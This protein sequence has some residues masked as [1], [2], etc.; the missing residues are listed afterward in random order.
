MG[1]KILNVGEIAKEFVSFRAKIAEMLR[2]NSKK[3]VLQHK[4]QK[5]MSANLARIEISAIF[6]HGF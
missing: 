4:M 5:K 6:A 2:K 1:A 3:Y